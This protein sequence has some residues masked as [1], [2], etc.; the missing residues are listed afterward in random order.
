MKETYYFSHDYNP[1]NDPKIICLIGNYGGLGYGVFWR[2]IEMLHQEEENKLPL[3]EYIYEAIAKQMLTS[4]EQIK[5]IIDD[6]LDKYELFSA[7]EEFFWSDRVIRN[8]EKRQEISEKRS[9]AG[10]KSIEAKQ[11]KTNVKQVLTSVKQVLTKERKGKEIKENKIIDSNSEID[12]PLTSPLQAPTEGKPSPSQEAN[13]FFT[14]NTEQL[15]V[16]TEIT[17][18]GINYD[19]ARDEVIK[20]V[21]YWTELNKSGTKQRW[22]LEK[23]FEVGRRLANWFSRIKTFGEKQKVIINL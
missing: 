14:S 13:R 4:A 7:D 12:K 2:I 16:I 20:F 1:T 10:K 15:R 9:L 18:K 11:L 6:C 21:F 17:A 19:T 5:A 3:K 8:I 22:E 23:T